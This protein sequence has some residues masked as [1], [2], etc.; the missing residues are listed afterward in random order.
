MEYWS[1]KKITSLK[2]NEIFVFGS[3]PSGIHGAGAA[4]DA[5]AFG[6][7]ITVGRGLQGQTYALVTKNLEGKEGFY[8]KSTGITY[9][10]A[11]Y[12]SV[13]PKQICDNID[14]MYECARNNPDKKFIVTYQHEIGFNGTPKTSLNGYNSLQLLDLFV[15]SDIPSNIVFHESYKEELER[16]VQLTIEY[17]ERQKPK[18]EKEPQMN[19]TQNDNQKSG[20][21]YFFSLHSPYSNFHPARFEFRNI[22]FS[23]S[24]QFMMYS[25][26]KMF[27]NEDIAQQ[28]LEINKLPLVEKFLNGE[29]SREEIVK[30]KELAKQWNE[31]QKKVK[32]FG[33]EVKN[34]NDKVWSDKR[35][36]IVAVAVREKFSQNE[37]LKQ[38]LLSTGQTYM[39]E[40]SP[41]DKIWGIGLSEYDAKRTSPENWPGQNILGKVLDMVKEG[42]VA[43][44]VPAKKFKP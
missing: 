2:E 34:Y 29:V 28:I 27:N 30:D 33:R 6:A 10:K 8:E 40:A 35:F 4:K 11:G 31:I 37:D 22:V 13:S 7:K 1:G 25:K 3:N 41:Y 42:L 21:T 16:R 12:R 24:E 43:E 23:S 18:Q 39:V 9:E 17:E 20:Y 32:G 44:A 15:T 14:E 36:N 5:R 26:A 19:N 38:T